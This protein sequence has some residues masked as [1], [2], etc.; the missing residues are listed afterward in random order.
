MGVVDK[1]GNLFG[2]INVVDFTIIFL[3]VVIIPMFLYAY[4]ILG[5]TPIRG[6]QE[7]VRVEAVVL[8]LPQIADLLK[9]GD[10][11]IDEHGNPDGK[12]IKVIERGSRIAQAVKDMIVLKT[13]NQSALSK[14]PVLLEPLLVEFELLCSRGSKSEPWYYRRDPLFINLGDRS[15]I[16]ITDKYL[17]SFYVTKIL[18]E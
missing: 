18:E 3:L 8:T 1:K 16:F 13:T 5:R 12:L 15:L 10:V 2:K 17:V 7:W 9:T 14:I 6:K 11:S 4:H